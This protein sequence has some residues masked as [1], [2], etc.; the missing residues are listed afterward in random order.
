MR[1]TARV[2][3]TLPVVAEMGRHASGRAWLARLPTLIEEL[4]VAW[5][6]RLG[7][8]FHG[9][10]CSWVAPARREG[11]PG[12]G[13]LVLKV[14]WPHREAAG[15]AEALRLWDGRGAV[16]VVA[17]DA[18]RTALLL[19]RCVPGTEL[20]SAQGLSPQEQLTCG[21]E[22]LRELASAAVPGHRTLE[23][24]GNVT[25]EWA[26]LLE[27][28]AAR[29]L[30]PGADAGVCALG[31]RLLRDLPVTAAREVVVHGDAN[32]GNFL[33]AGRRPWLA[34]DAKPMVG[35]PDYDPWPLIGQIGEPFAAPDPRAVLRERFALVAGLTGGDASR[36]AAWA[37]A[38]EA[39]SALWSA[40]H[41]AAP[42][43]VAEELRRARVLAELAG[44]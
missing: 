4:R 17:H 11:E 24:L 21:A 18:A 36:A 42:P 23:R 35:D 10:S 16:R 40:E 38:R 2:L 33:A 13:Q 19:E 5:G 34:I 29:L 28:R 22:V 1:R 44:A 27:E 31:A 20:W 32:P 41:G 12:G 7:A 3:G 15:E 14:T 37:A 9:G 6:L 26:E 25:A 39:E 43:A 8:P 30:P